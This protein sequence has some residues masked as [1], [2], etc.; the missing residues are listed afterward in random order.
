MVS[1]VDLADNGISDIL[2]QYLLGNK[3]V[4]TLPDEIMLWMSLL[5]LMPRSDK[6]SG[7]DD[8]WTSEIFPLIW[9][10]E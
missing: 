1:S 5:C 8:S 3:P 7:T 4:I 6:I 10:A 9:Q 2:G